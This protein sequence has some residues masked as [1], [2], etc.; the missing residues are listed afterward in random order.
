MEGVGAKNDEFTIGHVTGFFL[1]LNHTKFTH[2][3]NFCEHSLVY[4]QYSF[5]S[6][7]HLCN[8]KS[9]FE[10]VMTRELFQKLMVCILTQILIRNNEGSPS[11]M[12]FQTALF[13]TSFPCRCHI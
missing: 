10:V 2:T 9:T 3:A 8:A 7:G 6:M 13:F 11:T 4:N 12:L 5:E 1:P